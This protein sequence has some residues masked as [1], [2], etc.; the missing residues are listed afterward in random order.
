M[1]SSSQVHDH[2]DPPGRTGR[3]S[4]GAAGGSGRGSGATRASD[5]NKSPKEKDRKPQD[6]DER[7]RE[8]RD[9]INKKSAKKD[10]KD[11]KKKKKRGANADEEG[12]EDD[13]ADKKKKKKKDKKERR[14]TPV[15]GDAR[16]HDV[17]AAVRLRA[18]AAEDGA[19]GDGGS[20]RAAL[21]SPE[22]CAGDVDLP[23]LRIV[24]QQGGEREF[25]KLADIYCAR[26]HQEQPATR[27]GAEVAKVLK[28]FRCALAEEQK[29]TSSS[30]GGERSFLYAACSESIEEIGQVLDELDRERQWVRSFISFFESD[31]CEIMSEEELLLRGPKSATTTSKNMS[32]SPEEKFRARA[33]ELS[34]LGAVLTECQRDQHAQI[35]RRHRHNKAR[36]QSGQ[37]SVATTNR[38]LNLDVENMDINVILSL[39]PQDINSML[40][41]LRAKIEASSPEDLQKILLNVHANAFN[42]AVASNNKS[43]AYNY[44]IPASFFHVPPTSAS[45]AVGFRVWCELCSQSGNVATA[46]HCATPKHMT[47]VQLWDTMITADSATIAD[48]VEPYR[49]QYPWVMYLWNPDETSEGYPAHWWPYCLLCSED[50]FPNDSGQDLPADAATLKRNFKLKPVAQSTYCFPVAEDEMHCG[51]GSKEHEKRRQYFESGMLYY[52]DV[53]KLR[54]KLFRIFYERYAQHHKVTPSSRAGPGGARVLEI[55]PAAMRPAGDNASA[56][57]LRLLAPHEYEDL[58]DVEVDA[59]HACGGASNE[60]ASEDRSDSMHEGDAFPDD[61]DALS[62]KRTMSRGAA[63]FPPPGVWDSDADSA[64]ANDGRRAR[65]GD[66]VNNGSRVRDQQY[67]DHDQA[68]RIRGPQDQEEHISRGRCRPIGSGRRGSTPGTGQKQH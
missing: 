65:V 1:S 60:N 25:A 13:E 67:D 56:E 61:R 26:R 23:Q 12:Q 64:H 47:Y 38:N 2:S 43:A 59:P 30:S 63:G 7:R 46:E 28:Q 39:A 20:S 57:L 44:N 31:L 51:K 66:G 32:L 49:T 14:S 37:S 6:E 45:P 8:R 34:G 40:P 52:D 3:G 16:V 58:E 36:R 41:T 4:A 35:R 50:R 21:R 10:K 27:N 11:D 17:D 55:V 9:N 19:Q 42:V 22:C 29:R 62:P 33:P 68:E 5:Y 18:R 15:D 53:S 24:Q 54:W 48:L